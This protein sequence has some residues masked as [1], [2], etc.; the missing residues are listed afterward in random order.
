MLPLGVGE[1]F[2]PGVTLIATSD[3]LAKQR[4]EEA[5]SRYPDIALPFGWELAKA[6][7]PERAAQ[8]TLSS[9][10]LLRRILA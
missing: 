4:A 6:T 1:P 3:R 2:V 9:R 7:V 5:A 8:A 10:L